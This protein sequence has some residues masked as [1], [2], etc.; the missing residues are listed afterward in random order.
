[1]PTVLRVAGF[2]IAVRTEDHGP[3]HVHVL[4]AGEE[5]VINLG[6]RSDDPYVRDNRGMR[7]RN[8][9]KAIDIITANKEFLLVEW[10]RFHG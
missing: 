10:R 2:Q 8:V 5:V 6:S 4:S 3:P 7:R 1:M 9:G